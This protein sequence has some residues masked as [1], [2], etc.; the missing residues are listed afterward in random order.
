MGE[1]TDWD[2][3]KEWMECSES[4]PSSDKDKVVSLG[5]GC[6]LR[7]QRVEVRSSAG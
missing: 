4:G 7:A 5:A 6:A 1:G 2:W 3:E